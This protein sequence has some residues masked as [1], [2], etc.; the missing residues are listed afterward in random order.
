MG[1]WS[2]VIEPYGFQGIYMVGEVSSGTEALSGL[3]HDYASPQVGY[4]ADGVIVGAFDPDF[5]R[6]KRSCP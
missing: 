1:S 3:R 4:A 6:V 5:P 2:V